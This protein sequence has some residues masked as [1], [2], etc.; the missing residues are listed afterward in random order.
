MF[1][2][3]ADEMQIMLGEDFGEAG[4]LRQE[5]VAG[6]HGIGARDLAGREQRG[7]VEIGVLRRRRPDA[8]ALVGEPHMHGVGVGGGMHRD[9]VDA[10][11]LARAQHA[12]RDLAAIGYQD[13]VEHATSGG[14]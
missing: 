13:F 3:R 2:L 9:G 1:G 6:M 14:E 10:E 4:V 12:E 8:D 11:L 5:A 7:D